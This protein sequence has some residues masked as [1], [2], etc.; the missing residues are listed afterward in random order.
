MTGLAC[1]ESGGRYDAYNA[2]SGAY[3]KYQIMPR[4]WVGWTG[5]YLGNP[6]QGPTARAQEYVA[7]ARIAD[8]WALHHSWA[9]VAHWW[10]TGNAEPDRTLWSNANNSYVNAVIAIAQLA[11]STTTAGQVPRACF[12]QNL[13]APRIWTQPIPRV[14]VTGRRVFIRPGPGTDN[15]AVGIVTEGT[16]L[17][18][19]GSARDSSGNKW[20]YVGLRGGSTAWI[21][22]WFTEP[23]T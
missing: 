12:A 9:L 11:R 23:R 10:H 2:T 16:V 8:L 17:A 18:A 4:N 20:L 6:W 1:I 19:L 5:R 3:G 14:V 21:A 22:A 13:P 15:R 7:K